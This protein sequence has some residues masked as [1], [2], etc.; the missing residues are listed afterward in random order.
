V[1]QQVKLNISRTAF[2]AEKFVGRFS[3]A[4]LMYHHIVAKKERGWTAYE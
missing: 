1:A 4:R 2:G 3:E